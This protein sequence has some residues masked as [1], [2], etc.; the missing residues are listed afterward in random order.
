MIAGIVAA[1][2]SNKED[3]QDEQFT[4]ATGVRSRRIATEGQNTITL[5]IAAARRL[6]DALGWEGSE[7]HAVIFVT[8]SAPVSMPALSCRVAH[9][10]GAG[11]AA[12]D[13]S[14]ACSGFVYGIVLAHMFGTRKT[15]LVAGD[16]VSRMVNK[17]D[18]GTSN[19]FGDCV[20][21]VGIDGG[22]FLNVQMGTDGGGW[23]KLIADP[24]IRMD[25]P[26]VFSFAI[27]AVPKLIAAT[28]M[29]ANVDLYLMHQAN[30]R[31]LE[32]IIKK[33]KLDPEKCPINISEWGNTSSASIPLLMASSKATERLKTKRSRVGLFGFGAG[34]SHAGAM[35]DLEP[36]KVCEVI[37]T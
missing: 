21:A 11:C 17:E 14:L 4:K 9:E 28:T 20:A 2:P 35:L 24:Y 36:M 33:S 13:V 15:L 31:L 16:C 1:V 26:E 7:L 27:N 19:L 5:G 3:V 23:D 22:R 18:K 37:E 25:G 8:Q 34:F 10:V 6:L 12:F 30:K 29:N 32:H